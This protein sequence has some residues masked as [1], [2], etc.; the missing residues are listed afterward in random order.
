[1]PQIYDNIKEQRDQRWENQKGP[2]MSNGPA[3]PSA[4]TD[5]WVNFALVVI[6]LAFFL[7]MLLFK[8]ASGEEFQVN[9]VASGAPVSQLE[10]VDAFQ[11]KDSY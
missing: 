9:A 1:M 8:F 7:V 10:K 4:Q 3:G 5:N 6:A 2:V 11:A